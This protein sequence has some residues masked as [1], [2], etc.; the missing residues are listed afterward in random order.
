MAEMGPT[1]ILTLLL[2]PASAAEERRG[3]MVAS[4]RR[5]EFSLLLVAFSPFGC[6]RLTSLEETLEPW[7]AMNERQ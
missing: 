7:P 5:V 6:G 3:L 1:E 2:R 4:A